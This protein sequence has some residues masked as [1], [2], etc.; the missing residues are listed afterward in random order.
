[1]AISGAAVDGLILKLDKM[2]LRFW[3]AVLNLSMGDWVLF[4]ASACQS[5][6]SRWFVGGGKFAVARC[7]GVWRKLLKMP[8]MRNIF[9]Q[10]QFQQR[11]T[12]S[13]HHLL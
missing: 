13:A 8:V 2:W 11:I 1:M 3:L 9:T 7:P 10:V 12:W 4:P 5:D 6:A